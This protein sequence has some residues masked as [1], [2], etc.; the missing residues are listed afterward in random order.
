MD[1]CLG[2]GCCCNDI[3]TWK[4]R[5][6]VGSIGCDSNIVDYLFKVDPLVLPCR[7]CSSRW[8]EE[9]T[10]DLQKIVHSEMMHLVFFWANMEENS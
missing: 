6:A 10:D 4:Q 3:N 7:H 8:Q 2:L 1:L 5:C 9:K